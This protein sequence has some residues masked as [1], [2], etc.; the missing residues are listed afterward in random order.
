MHRKIKNL[1]VLITAI[2][3]ISVVLWPAIRSFFHHKE[4]VSLTFD[5]E[6]LSNAARNIQYQ[7]FDKNSR[8]YILK[9]LRG[10]ETAD[11][12]ITFDNPEIFITTPEGKQYTVTSKIGIYY[13]DCQKVDLKD[14]VYFVDLD[15]MTL[16]TEFAKIDLI[17]GI[18]ENDEDVAVENNRSK[19]HAKGFK[20]ESNTGKIIF[21]G[22]PKLIAK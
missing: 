12:T 5:R 18:A 19:M 6:I 21:K 17:K 4:S 20:I 1:L 9:A 7:G 3:G 10:A 11:N 14:N 15:G 8:K 13:K 22:R 2:C 16:R